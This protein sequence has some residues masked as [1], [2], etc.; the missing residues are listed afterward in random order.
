MELW[1]SENYRNSI[2]HRFCGPRLHTRY[3]AFSW[4]ALFRVQ[5]YSMSS[6]SLQNGNMMTLTGNRG[7][8]MDSRKNSKVKDGGQLLDISALE[9]GQQCSSRA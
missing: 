2:I 7:A 3:M 1:G 4:G 5:L 8:L 9:D 6:F